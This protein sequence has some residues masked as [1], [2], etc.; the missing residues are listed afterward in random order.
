MTQQNFEPK[1][2]AFCCNWC[3]Y[4]G[5]D[6]AGTGRLKYPENIRIIRVP[7]SSRVEVPL[8]MRAFQNG[9]DGVMVAGCHPGDCHY[10]TGNYHTRRRMILMQKVL[11]FMGIS[12]DRLLVKWISGNEAAKF[13]DTVE[14]FNERLKKLGA[15]DKVRDMRCKK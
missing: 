9:A 12:S 10:N 14:N 8:V 15:A 5:A 1:I 11:D 6:L 7:C 2:V 4:A 13:K 3:S